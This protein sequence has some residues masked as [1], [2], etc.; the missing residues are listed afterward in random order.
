MSF[1]G[2]VYRLDREEG[3]RLIGVILK[4]IRGPKSDNSRDAGTARA[5]CD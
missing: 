4:A 1:H 3:K 2:C 5:E